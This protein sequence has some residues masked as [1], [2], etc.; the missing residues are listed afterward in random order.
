M[1]YCSHLK[2]F[3]SMNRVQESAVIRA[4]FMNKEM[5]G[6]LFKLNP[7]FIYNVLGLK[8]WFAKVFLEKKSTNGK[9]RFWHSLEGRLF[10]GPSLQEVTFGVSSFIPGLAYKVH[11]PIAPN[12]VKLTTILGSGGISHWG[13]ALSFPSNCT[14]ICICLTQYGIDFKSQVARFYGLF[15]LS[16]LFGISFSKLYAKLWVCL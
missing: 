8:H 2:P 13:I 12:K 5:L 6:K 9:Q 3:T 1:T 16:P 10:L 14:R 7:Q 15:Y 11:T 4:F